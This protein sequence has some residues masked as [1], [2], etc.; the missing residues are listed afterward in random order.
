MLLDENLPQL[1]KQA[2]E[3]FEVLTVAQAGWA[4]AKNGALLRLAAESFD[5]FVT[6][7]CNLPHHQAL[8]NLSLSTVILALGSTKLNDLR[9]A[10]P[11]IWESITQVQ[12]GQVVYVR[13]A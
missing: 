11:A 8:G 3:V 6:A 12:P 1:L 2:L 4:G 7:D 9:T 5:V 13:P 10:A